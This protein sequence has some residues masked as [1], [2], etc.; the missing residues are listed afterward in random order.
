MKYLHFLP[1]WTTEPFTDTPFIPIQS[2][3]YHLLTVYLWL[4][5]VKWHFLT[6]PSISL[7]LSRHFCN[8]LQFLFTETKIY[9]TTLNIKDCIQWNIGL[10]KK[11]YKHRSIVFVF[12]FYSPRKKILTVPLMS[13]YPP[14][15]PIYYN[16]R[17]VISSWFGVQWG[18]HTIIQVLNKPQFSHM[19]SENTVNREILA[20]TVNQKHPS[21]PAGDSWPPWPSTRSTSCT[22][23]AFFCIGAYSAIVTNRNDRKSCK[24]TRFWCFKPAVLPA[25]CC[26]FFIRM[27]HTPIKVSWVW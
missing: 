11:R 18:R 23:T 22:Q 7:I 27:E 19:W 10:K 8:I 16:I 9:F 25:V 3:S 15:L 13:C 26:L 6:F 14:S 20:L 4:K 21:S 17:L 2:W 1:L 24:K 12:T 5:Q